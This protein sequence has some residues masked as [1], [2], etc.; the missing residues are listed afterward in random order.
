M[1]QQQWYNL[2]ETARLP[3][4]WHTSQ[5]EQ[6]RQAGMPGEV[7]LLCFLNEVKISKDTRP[8]MHC[9]ASYASKTSSLSIG[10]YLYSLQTKHVS[11]TGFASAHVL[12]QHM[13]LT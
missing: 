3:L 7:S 9:K 12:P 11:S 6:P 13:S 4:N 8:K 5:Q 1:N 10:F 2:A